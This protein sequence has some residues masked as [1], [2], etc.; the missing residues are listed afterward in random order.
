MVRLIACRISSALSASPSFFTTWQ[1][2]MQLRVP[3]PDRAICAATPSL[4][5]TASL[6]M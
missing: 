1:A 2:W 6:T 4:V 5:E 3:S